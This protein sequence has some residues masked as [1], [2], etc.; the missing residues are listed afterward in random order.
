MVQVN[1]KLRG[2]L[3]VSVDLSKEDILAQA[4]ALPEVQ[5]I[6]GRPTSGAAK[7]I[8]SKVYLTQK[9]WQQAA[10]KSKE[11]IDSKVYDLFENYADVFNVATKNGKE[12]AVKIQSN[13]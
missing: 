10:E 1:G 5:Q 6:N 13:L 11:I 2:K 3:E 7:S 4:K 8:L 9:K 12:L